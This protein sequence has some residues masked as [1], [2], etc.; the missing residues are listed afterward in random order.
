[1]QYAPLASRV[2]EGHRGRLAA[3]AAHDFRACVEADHP[4]RRSLRDMRTVD[5]SGSGA[6]AD[7]LAHLPLVDASCDERQSEPLVFRIVGNQEMTLAVAHCVYRLVHGEQQYGAGP[8]LGVLDAEAGRDLCV[9]APG[10]AVV[11][12]VSVNEDRVDVAESAPLDL[13]LAFVELGRVEQ[14]E[15][16][17]ELAADTPETVE[18]AEVGLGVE[19]RELLHNAGTSGKR[20][21]EQTFSQGATTDA[22][23]CAQRGGSSM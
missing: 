16:V 5:A 14:V 3:E 15:G 6:A 1:M 13:G 20:R 9:V 7:Q 23:R 19:L 21:G 4:Q 12:E 18:G 8:V 2:G 11:L 17:V 10:G 22:G